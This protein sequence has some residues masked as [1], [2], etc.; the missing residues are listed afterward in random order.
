MVLIV[1]DASDIFLAGARFYFE[2]HFKKNNI[3][4]GIILVLLFV[5]WIYFRLV[6]FPFCL[7]SNVYINAPLPSDEWA[8]IYY[9]YMYLVVMAFLLVGMHIY[10]T[11]FLFRSAYTSLGKKKIVNNY[12]V[13]KK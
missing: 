2:S 13:H 1:H 3:I 10:W 4:T 6:V 7:L 8:F 5:M 11:L 12:D 9:E